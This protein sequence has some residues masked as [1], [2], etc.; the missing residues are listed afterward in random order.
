MK[1]AAEGSGENFSN[2]LPLSA[3]IPA[4]NRERE[5]PYKGRKKAMDPTHVIIFK[6]PGAKEATTI[7]YYGE[8]YFGR[9]L[10]TMKK[11]GWTILYTGK[12]TE[13]QL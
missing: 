3:H 6:I 4:R 13:I 7:V 11:Q 12:L 2:N 5:C 10:S 8:I 9:S 1:G